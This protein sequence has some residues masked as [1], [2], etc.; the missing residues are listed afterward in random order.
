M[1]CIKCGVK[2]A[3]TEPRC[4]LCGTEVFHPE[5]IREQAEPLYPQERYPVPQVNSRATQIVMTT[6][7]LLGILTTLLCDMQINGAV[8]WSGYVIGAVLV[9]YV[10]MV[11]PFWFRRSNPVIFVPCTFT[12]AGLYLFYINWATGGNWFL[13]FALPV[14]AGVGVILTALAALLKY[15]RRGYLYIFGGANIALGLFMPLVEFLLCIT[16]DLTRFVGWSL[17]PLI[18][19]VLL[20]GMLIFLAICRPARETMERKFFI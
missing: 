7:A 3:D 13:S 17:Y 18:A 10:A 15:V 8:T 16:F 9:G 19:L 20:G 2:L 6:L 5:L 11:L 12:A 1:Y 14:T 4:P